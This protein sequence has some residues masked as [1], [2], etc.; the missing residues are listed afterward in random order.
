MGKVYTL[1]LTRNSSNVNVLF[2]PLLLVSLRRCLRVPKY[3]CAVYD[4]ARKGYLGLLESKKKIG[5]NYA[6][7]LEIIK[8]QLF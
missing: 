5:G 2:L 8:Q 7:F 1:L 6:F 4:Y 3:F